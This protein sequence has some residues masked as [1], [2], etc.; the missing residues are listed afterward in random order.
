MEKR[1]DTRRRLGLQGERQAAEHLTSQG[2]TIAASNWRCPSGE[3]DLVAEHDGLLIFIEVRSRR[4]T[5]TYGTA[6]ESVDARKQKKIRDTAQL[7]MYR[8]KSFD[9][10]VRFDVVTVYYSLDG[11]FLRLNHIKGAF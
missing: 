6:E 8:T 10:R 5:G 7:Y 3:L 2:Y 4:E 1:N 11:L 9:K